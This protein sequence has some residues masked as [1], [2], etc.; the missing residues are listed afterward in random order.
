MSL[1]AWLIGIPVALAIWLAIFLVVAHAAEPPV[2]SGR[3]CQFY[4]PGGVIRVWRLAAELDVLSHKTIVV[5]GLCASACVI[6]IGEALQLGGNV[7]IDSKARLVWGHDP[8]WFKQWPMPD[9]FR[10]RVSMQ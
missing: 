4:G 6:A 3:V 9:W 7:V 2:C 1:R 5:S 10:A 8:V